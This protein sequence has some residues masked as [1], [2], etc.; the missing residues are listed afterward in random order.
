MR[1]VDL[2]GGGVHPMS[3]AFRTT[4][5]VSSAP[6]CLALAAMQGAQRQLAQCAQETDMPLLEVIEAADFL[7]EAIRCLLSAW[8][9]P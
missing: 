6:L 9:A 7:D 1:R 5:N 8:E 2:A 4:L 3:A